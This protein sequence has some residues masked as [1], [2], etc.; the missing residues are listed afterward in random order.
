MFTIRYVYKYLKLT[1]NLAMQVEIPVKCVSRLH[2]NNKHLQKIFQHAVEAVNPKK[3]IRDN[4]KIIGEKLTIRDRNYSLNNK[5]YVV[6]YGK[7]VLNMATEVEA[8]L[9]QNLNSGI[10]SIPTGTLSSEE[11]QKM[12]ETSKIRVI[13]AAQNNIP[14]IKSIYAT[15]EICKLVDSLRKN[16]LLIVLISGGGS[17]L[18]SLP[19]PQIFL[20]DKIQIITSLSKN[21]AN[22]NELNSFRKRVSQVKGGG[23]ARKAFPAYIVSLILSDVI[24]DPLD[25]IASGTTVP[26]KD[27]PNQALQILK[28]YSV[29]VPQKVLKVLKAPYEEDNIP[30]NP[31]GEYFHVENY[32]IGN[33]KLMIDAAKENSILRMYE[34]AVIS[35][36]IQGKVLELA[37]FYAE[38]AID[39]VEIMLGISSKEFVKLKYDEESRIDISYT[40]PDILALDFS[41]KKGM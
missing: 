40:L 41:N 37:K 25:I 24:D 30:L 4:V 19:I 29:Q 35:T 21:G 18:L 39:L 9:G 20:N 34:T 10:I 15:E 2:Y 31:L 3:L 22:I 16:D 33:N 12:A 38:L 14:D 7:A 1:K 26:N 11:I 5:I 27:D 6:G 17:A 8:I 32:L 36:R 28:K 23:L 13:Q